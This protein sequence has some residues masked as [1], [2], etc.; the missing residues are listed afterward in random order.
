M[1]NMKDEYMN[2]L[3]IG[4]LIFIFVV[5]VVVVFL[6][7]FGVIETFNVDDPNNIDEGCDIDIDVEEGDPIY[8]SDSLLAQDNYDMDS[9]TTSKTTDLKEFDLSIPL[10]GLENQKGKESSSDPSANTRSASIRM[11]PKNGMKCAQLPNGK[12]RYEIFLAIKVNNKFKRLT[13]EKI[14]INGKSNPSDP[15]E[16]G[17]PF[18]RMVITV[19]K[20]KMFNSKYIN[21]G[22]NLENDI[23]EIESINNEQIKTNKKEKASNISVITKRTITDTKGDEYHRYIMLRDG[24]NNSCKKFIEKEN[25]ITFDDWIVKGELGTFEFPP[26]IPLNPP[27]R[28]IPIKSLPPQSNSCIIDNHKIS[29][30][31]NGRILQNDIDLRNLIRINPIDK[32]IIREDGL[33][34]NF[35]NTIMKRYIIKYYVMV[36]I[37]EQLGTYRQASSFIPIG[38]LYFDKNITYDVQ[39]SFSVN[40]SSNIL[41]EIPLS[42]T[43]Q[44]LL[45]RD[46]ISVDSTGREYFRKRDVVDVE[47]CGQ[48]YRNPQNIIWNY[49]IMDNKVNINDVIN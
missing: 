47:K 7:I 3:F 25:E 27:Q 6:V 1:V 39:I 18:K 24:W 38:A 26:D 8:E 28:I 19:P 42:R 45:I 20:K 4:S 31:P 5:L 13:N 34:G 32:K 2:K 16:S 9:G 36:V 48:K 46:A 30:W 11:K 17:A 49:N 41:G 44:L 10:L 12:I 29:Y 14:I 37:V 40:N 33:F 23:I 15:F 43:T 21:I 22:R 35:L